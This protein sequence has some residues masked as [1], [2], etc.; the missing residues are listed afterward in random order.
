[1]VWYDELVRRSQL[2]SA[3]REKRWKNLK[4]NRHQTI[5]SSHFQHLST[6]AKLLPERPFL[7]RS[8][9]SIRYICFYGNHNLIELCNCQM[10]FIKWPSYWCTFVIVGGHTLG[11]AHCSSF[12][13]RIHNFSA[14]LD[15]DPSL[16]ASF[17]AS[18][19]NVCPAHNKVKSAGSTMDS[20]TTIF[21]NAYYKL[22]LQGKSI[23]S[24]DQSLLTTP[25]T[26]ALV[27]KFARSQQEFDN[28]FVKSMIKMSSITGGQEIRLDCRVVN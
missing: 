28:A 14:S 8:C 18:L 10:I 20:T 6:T 9:S 19:R 21:D 4:G 16:Q 2:E 22:L 23:F 11:F 1:M 17:A 26:K 25:K 3:K 15:I 27:S 7:G 12:Q 5:A 13:N 24:S